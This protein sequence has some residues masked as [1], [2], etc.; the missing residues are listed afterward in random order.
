MRRGKQT[1]YFEVKILVESECFTL[2]EGL[3]QAKKAVE[4]MGL[5]V[6]EILPV[7]STRTITQNN[8]LHLYLT[9]WAETLNEHGIGMKQIV[10]KDLD[11]PPTMQLLK[12]NVWKKIQ[13]AMYGHNSTKDL[14]KQEEINK[15]VDVITKTFGERFKLYVPWPSLEILM[16]KDNPST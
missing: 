8:A 5:K 4:S 2:A 9:Q 13:R 16:D 1:R 10:R 6:H 11:I 3:I 14:D 12:D 7:K 15:I